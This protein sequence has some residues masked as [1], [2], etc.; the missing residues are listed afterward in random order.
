MNALLNNF[1]NDSRVDMVSVEALFPDETSP[2]KLNRESK[3]FEELQESI[4]TFGILQPLLIT[5][6]GDGY[7]IISGTRR[8]VIAKELGIEL[9]PAI[10]IYPQNDF[11]INVI[12]NDLNLK[13]RKKIL[14]SEMAKAFK[15]E[16]ESVSVQGKRTDL[17]LESNTSEEDIS[18]VNN[19]VVIATKYNISKSTYY[20]YIQLNNLPE[21]ILYCV[22][23]ELISVR[24]A[25]DYIIKLNQHNMNLL[26]MYCKQNKVRINQKCIQN[27]YKAQELYG[28]LSAEVIIEIIEGKEKVPTGKEPSIKLNNQFIKNYIPSHLQTEELQITYIEKAI[29]FYKAHTENL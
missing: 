20:R 7:I 3:D 4:E 14:P 11:E 18:S 26:A 6:K 29:E 10:I 24:T 13:V 25:A 2:W 22:D 19:A 21:E 8:W 15:L 28:E 9:V 27:I 1:K 17:L 23:L 12:R 16:M 5:R